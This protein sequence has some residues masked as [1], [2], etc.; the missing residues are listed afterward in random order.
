MV[1]QEIVYCLLS[2]VP[3]EKKTTGVSRR[4]PKPNHSESLARCQRKKKPIDP[5]YCTL[6]IQNTG[7]Y[8]Y[9]GIFLP[10]KSQAQG[11]KK[12]KDTHA[13]IARRRL[14]LSIMVTLGA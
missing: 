5:V 6:S 11:E 2:A 1:V 8:M 13:D 7:S 14:V 10:P 12:N 4:F 3:R 9:T